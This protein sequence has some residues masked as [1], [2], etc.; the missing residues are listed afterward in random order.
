MKTFFKRSI[1]VFFSLIF[2]FSFIS[3]NGVLPMAYAATGG[4]T[5]AEAVAWAKSQEGQA[6]DYIPDGTIWC[7]DLIKGYY[8]FLGQNLKSIGQARYLYNSVPPGWRVLYLRESPI[9][10]PGDIAVWTA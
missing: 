5:Q 10:Q 1:S 6:I 8:S 2:A 9:P 7:V 4:H 3:I